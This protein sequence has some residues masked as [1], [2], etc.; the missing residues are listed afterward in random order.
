MSQPNSQPR[1]GGRGQARTRPEKPRASRAAAATASAAVN[2]DDRMHESALGE[3][4]S[5][6][7]RWA[8][9]AAASPSIAAADWLAQDINPGFDS[10][11]ELLT[12]DRA[13]VEDLRKAKSAFKTMRILGETVADRR[14]GARLYL[15]AIASGLVHHQLRISRQSDAALTRALDRLV[16]DRGV[17]PRLQQLAGTAICSLKTWPPPESPLIADPNDVEEEPEDLEDPGSTAP[18]ASTRGTG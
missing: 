12:S 15:A 7:L 5:A 1:R 9:E 11:I 10:A 18:R 4:L 3:K 8:L 13:S 14:L 17:D 6:P 16:S 2:H